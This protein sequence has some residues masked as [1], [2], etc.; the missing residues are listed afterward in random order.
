M[1]LEKLHGGTNFATCLGHWWG[2]IF[3]RIS[4]AVCPEPWAL[5]TPPCL[6]EQWIGVKVLKRKLGTLQ[7]FFGSYQFS[8]IFFCL[9]DVIFT[10]HNSDELLRPIFHLP[11]KWFTIVWHFWGW[12]IWVLSNWCTKGPT[13]FHH[14]VPTRPYCQSTKSSWFW[15]P[16]SMGKMC[17]DPAE[18]QQWAFPR[19]HL[20]CL[21]DL[22]TPWGRRLIPVTSQSSPFCSLFH[23]TNTVIR[24]LLSILHDTCDA[25]VLLWKISLTWLRE[26][27]ALDVRGISIP[28]LISRLLLSAAGRRMEKVVVVGPAQRYQFKR[29]R[30][31]RTQ[32][33]R[34][35]QNMTIF[36]WGT[37]LYLHLFSFL[38]EAVSMSICLQCESKK[39]WISFLVKESFP[40]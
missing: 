40:L 12:R 4:W 35:K 29:G 33:L 28:A 32:L 10:V 1:K 16:D 14:F 15:T 20:R 39:I 11:S 5:S 26:I 2:S 9:L 18:H 36:F 19:I 3:C 6:P 30:R 21:Q 37:Q 38:F 25:L 23:Q 24:D 27:G 7:T 22:L 17:P 34:T 31:N 13:V 8:P